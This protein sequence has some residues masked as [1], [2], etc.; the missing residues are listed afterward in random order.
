MSDGDDAEHNVSHRG[1]RCHPHYRSSTEV[2]SNTE[3]TLIHPLSP[4]CDGN[5]T[6]CREIHYAPLLGRPQLQVIRTSPVSGLPH[7]FAS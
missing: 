7:S 2:D 4:L 5:M 6:R 1:L 3:V